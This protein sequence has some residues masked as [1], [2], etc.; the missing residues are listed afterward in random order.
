MLKENV[1]PVSIAMLP[2]YDIVDV[3]R[4]RAI[5]GLSAFIYFLTVSL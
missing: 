5:R 4:L 2:D 1:T 3:M